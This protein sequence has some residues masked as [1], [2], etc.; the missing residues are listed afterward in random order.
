MLVC[1]T[2]VRTESG[3]AQKTTKSF[4]VESKDLDEGDEKFTSTWGA[5]LKT[6]CIWVHYGE[7]GTRWIGSGFIKAGKS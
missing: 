6:W 5:S 1:S 3:G 2:R 4:A 7:S